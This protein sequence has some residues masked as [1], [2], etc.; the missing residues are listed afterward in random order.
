MK[1]EQGGGV[2]KTANSIGSIVELDDQ[3]Q[4]KTRQSIQL[5]SYFK[6]FL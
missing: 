2:A 5:K 4:R 1:L 6:S 3:I